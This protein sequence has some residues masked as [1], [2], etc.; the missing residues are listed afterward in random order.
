MSE[1]LYY[2]DCYLREFEEVVVDAGEDRRRIVLDRTAFYP[3]SGGQPFD[4]GTLNDSAVIEVNESDSGIIHV[5]DRP[6][7][8]ERVRA[9]VNWER[10][11]DH[12][13]QHTGQHLL[14]AVFEELYGFKTV[15]FHLG[16]E[17]STIDLAALSL[18]AEQVRDV[19]RRANQVVFEN[20][21][22]RIAYEDATEAG[23]LRKP[24]EREGVLRIV[25]IEGLDRSACGGTH[26][27]ATGE[28]GPI[29]LRKT[30]KIRGNVRVEFLCGFRAVLRARKDYYALT[31]I[32]Q[33]FSAGIDEAATLVRAQSARVAEAE[34]ARRKL[35]AELAQSRGREIHAATVPGP[36]GIRRYVV[37]QQ[38]GPLAEEVR[39]EAQSFVAQGKAIFFATTEEPPS[40]LVGTSA[41]SGAHAGELVKAFTALNGGRGGG[42][43]QIAQGSVP[44]AASFGPL[45]AQLGFEH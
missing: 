6:L 19:E 20:R 43:A 29:V 28:I 12:M 27:R 22:V 45:K 18:T 44:S 17:E 30:E 42:N 10:R 40:V 2:D 39:I 36:D 34:K 9:A 38:K 14:S 33:I 24:S 5:L 26:V 35:A 41:D 7:T 31:E 15:S 21:A 11:F 4:L 1:R 8:G 13:Q 32:A 37:S 3:T 16:S 25:S 23:G